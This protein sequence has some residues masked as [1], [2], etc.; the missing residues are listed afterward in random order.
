MARTKR[1]PGSQQAGN[2]KAVW[3]TALYAR[4]SRDD[5]DK[6]ES[7]SIANQRKLL[8]RFLAGQAQMELADVYVDDGHTGYNFNR[9]DFQRMV[10]ENGRVFCS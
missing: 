7:D 4:L 6:P 10:E 1:I 5:G 2:D 8:E 3:R 9:P